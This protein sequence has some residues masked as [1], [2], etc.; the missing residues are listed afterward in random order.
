MAKGDRLI[1][2]VKPYYSRFILALFFM[3]MAALFFGLLPVIIKPLIDEMSPNSAANLPQVAQTVR[4]F[5]YNLLPKGVKLL[6]VLPFL[7]LLV[8]LGEAVFGFLSL[9]FMKTLGLKVVRDIRNKLYMNLVSQSVDFLSKA[10]T[11]DLTSRISNDIEKIGFAVSETLAVY[12]RDSLTLL[13]MMG[14]IFSMDWK[15]SFMSLVILPIAA[16]PL[17]YFGRKVKKRGIQAQ[18]TIGELSNFL[19]ETVAGN[20]IVKAYNMEEFEIEKFRQMN[21]KYYKINSKIAMVF[22]LSSPVM[23]FIGGFV[24]FI[25]FTIAI[26]RIDAGSMTPGGF[27]A[28]FLALLM[29]YDPIKKLSRAQND[30]QQGIAGFH[31]VLQIIVTSNPIKDSPSAVELNNVTGE[32]TFKNVT[33]S[34]RE[35]IPVLKNVNFNACPNRMI[36]L[37]GA[38]GSGKTTIMNLLLRFYEP[39]SGE[40]LIDGK[41]IMEVTQKSLRDTIG[42]VTQDV[43]IFNETIEKNIAYG[44]KTHTIDEVKDAARIARAAD[45][46]EELPLQYQSIAGER[47]VF[48]S[49]GQR[50]RISIARAVLKKP[51]ILIFDEATSSLDSESEKLIQEAMIDVMKGRTTFVI[52]HRL[53]TIIEADK[54]L[55]IQDGEIKESGNHRELLVKRGLYYSLYNLQFPEMDIIM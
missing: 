11:G 14:I 51:S 1:D 10:K 17:I 8:F 52:A 54:I 21:Q 31:R 38:S 43:F 45:F 23:T 39:D 33:F 25:I 26:H 35:D 5:F 20:K 24:A 15:L 42:L 28:F 44:S 7:L 22:S 3:I 37:V 41:N 27:A 30:Y 53:S 50:Q 47:G 55:V 16:A 36:A 19:A 49:T 46:I 34:Y 40:I 6:P 18:E 48:L 32:V 4:N 13:V 9:Y 2:Y 12:I 29:M